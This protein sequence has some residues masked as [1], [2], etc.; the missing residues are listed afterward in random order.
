MGGDDERAP[1]V[2]VGRLAGFRVEGDENGRDEWISPRRGRR[3][4]DPPELK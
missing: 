2:V 3:G 4:V 1:G